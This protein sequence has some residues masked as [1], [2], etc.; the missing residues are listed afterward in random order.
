MTRN[1]EIWHHSSVPEA[2]DDQSFL[3]L[4]DFFHSGNAPRSSIQF[5]FGL[6]T[7]KLRGELFV[8]VLNGQQ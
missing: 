8:I 6:F 4:H 2:V 7:L 5:R 3:L 1:L